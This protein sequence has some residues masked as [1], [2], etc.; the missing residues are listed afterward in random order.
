MLSAVQPKSPLPLVAGAFS[1]KVLITVC[2]RDLHF[3]YIG[4]VRAWRFVQIE[5][6][7]PSIGEDMTLCDLYGVFSWSSV[8]KHFYHAR[9]CSL[10]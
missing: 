2:G 10:F 1:E 4:E 8:V 7:I 9:T 5:T 6:F 3:G